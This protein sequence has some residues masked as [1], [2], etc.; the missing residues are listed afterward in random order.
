MEVFMATGT[1]VLCVTGATSGI[2]RATAVRFLREGWRVIAVGRRRERLDE[3]AAEYGENLLPLQLDVSDRDAVLKAFAAL[4][5]AFAPVDVLVNNAGGAYGQDKA[6][7][8]SL[9][10]WDIMVN[11]NVKGMM[12]CT[13]AVIG[14]M[15]ERGEGHIV[16]IGSVAAHTTYP[17]ANVYGGCKAF[18]YQFSDNLRSDLHGTGVRVTNVEPGLLESEFSFVRL[19]DPDKAAAV[20]SGCEPL[21]PEDL[22]DVIHF[23]VNAPRHVDIELVRVKP[24][25]QSAVANAIYRR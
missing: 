1:R 16:N 10:D 15:A 9:D 17:G 13:K 23:A 22:A 14:Q 25:C 3:L 8:A 12:Y 4:P 24:V 2:G 21:T 6:M 11:V 19:R 7:D 5:E 18:V 20:Y